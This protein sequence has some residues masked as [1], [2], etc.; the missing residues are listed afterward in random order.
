L[1]KKEKWKND[2]P[3]MSLILFCELR[4]TIINYNSIYHNVCSVATIARK[5]LDSSN[6]DVILMFYELTK[7]KNLKMLLK[8]CLM[9]SAISLSLINPVFAA[10]NKITVVETRKIIENSVAYAEIMKQVQKKNEQ[11]REEIQK[12]EGDLKKKYQELET[13]KNALSQDAIDKKN[14][15]ISKEVAELQKKSYGQHSTLE[16]AHRN[17]TQILVDKT[18]EIVKTQAEKNGYEIVIEKAAVFYSDAKLDITDAVLEE[19]NKALPTVE[20][21]FQSEEEKKSEDKKVDA[22]APKDKQEKK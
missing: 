1:D 20:V 11:F 21:K 12:S 7:L 8:K 18:T 15:E 9:I 17:A 16:E 5:V 2:Y 13:K 6:L 4:R 22:S 14:D 10:D 3:M 19:L